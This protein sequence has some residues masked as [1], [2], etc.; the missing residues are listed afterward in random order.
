MDDESAAE[1]EGWRHGG[2]ESPLNTLLTITR[3]QGFPQVPNV[4]PHMYGVGG[5]V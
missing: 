2:H 1:E 3:L 4:T 5:D